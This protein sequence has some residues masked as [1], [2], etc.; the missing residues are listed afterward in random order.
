MI[1]KEVKNKKELNRFIRFPWEIYKKY[2]RWVPPLIREQKRQ[3][4]PAHNNFLKESEA[5]LFLAVNEDNKVLGR[6]AAIKNVQHLE[7]YKDNTG[8][9]GFFECI[10]S[11]EVANAL[12]DKAGEWL[13]E[14]NLQRMRGPMSFTINEECGLLID[15]F[16][17]DPGMGFPYNPPYYEKLI[18][19]YGFE[20]AH[21]LFAF[22]FKPEFVTDSFRKKALKA[23]ERVESRDDIRLRAM[24]SPETIEEDCRILQK[25]YAEAWEGNWGHLPVDLEDII[26]TAKEHNWLIDSRLNWA[27]EYKGEIAGMINVFPDYAEAL[28]SMNGRLFPFGFINFMLNRRKN[29]KF[30][31][32]LMGILKK[33]RNIGIE[34]LFLKQIDIEYPKLG[35][36]EGE[37]SWILESNRKVISTIEKVGGKRY[38]TYRIFDKNL[39]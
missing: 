4:S 19:T 8:F 2:P 31:V 32:I 24:G 14:R 16:E 26:K 15:G 35:Y 5:Q 23:A 6:I 29:K 36:N 7:I 9:F 18:N 1:I 21:D 39:D 3:L 37:F 30:R 34:S 33:Y 13:S 20:K 27:V 11:Q 10:E 38:K 17:Y 28:R 25:I 22:H 12:F